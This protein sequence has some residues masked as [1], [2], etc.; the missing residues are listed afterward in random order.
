MN[1][2]DL[3]QQIHDAYADVQAK[4]KAR[5]EAAYALDLATT[6]YTDAANTLAGL[7]DQLGDVLGKALP[8]VDPRFRKSA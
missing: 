1:V 3:L 8:T 2:A 7:R 5:D 6:A 4:S